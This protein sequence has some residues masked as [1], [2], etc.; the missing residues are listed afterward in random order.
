MI[1]KMQK[2][3]F[4]VENLSFHT[5]S[6]ITFSLSPAAC[7][8]LSGPSGVGKTLFLRALADLDPHKGIICLEG[9]AA[10]S[11]SAPLWRRQV[12]LLP[13]EAAWW[14]NTVEEHFG[15]TN[16]E[17][18]SLL[19]FDPTVLKWNIS[20]LSSGEKQR[21]ALLRVLSNHPKVLLLDEPTANLDSENSYRIE[22]LIAQLRQQREVA[23]IW[24]SHNIDQLKRVATRHFI[25]DRTGFKEAACT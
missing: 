6:K 12:A 14:F 11:V 22:R 4:T 16:H 13:T 19:D 15:E 3:Y 7:L 25:L 10:A 5:F 20:R 2:N 18:L 9:V 23:V 21:L 8:G 17:W 1:E 24:V